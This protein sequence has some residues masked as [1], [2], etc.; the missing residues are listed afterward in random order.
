M[1]QVSIIMACVFLS[2][3]EFFAD[4]M[5]L[6]RTPTKTFA[7][8]DELQNYVT[9]ELTYKN[10]FTDHW[11]APQETID[12]GGGDCEDFAILVAY[13][14]RQFGYQ[15]YLVAMETPRGNHMIVMLNGKAYEP[16]TLKLYPYY[17]LYEQID[18]LTLE[19]AL[20][21]CYQN[22]SRSVEE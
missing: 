8:M 2:G 5:T 17:D 21:K 16:Q 18:R 14:A 12:R 13:Y 22:G 20:R 6:I 1:K 4:P 10:E 7:S 11:Q 3:C 9:Y 19:E 15:V